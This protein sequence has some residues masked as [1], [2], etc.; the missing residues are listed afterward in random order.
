[1]PTSEC[2]IKLRAK[3]RKAGLCRCGRER[4]NKK[5]KQCEV[6]RKDNR[7]W[8]AR[9]VKDSC[10]SDRKA[11][12]IPLDS[13]PEG[14]IDK[15]FVIHLRKKVQ[16]KCCYC[17]TVMQTEKMRAV[18]D[19]LTVERIDN[20]LPHLKSNCTLACWKCNHSKVGTLGPTEWRTKSQTEQLR[21]NLQ[22]YLRCLKCRLENQN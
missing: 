4:D 16:S 22:A 21:L 11:G 2:L 18:D 15:E 13:V 7:H 8:A 17:F 19:G 5:L 1:M 9:K 12:R 3:R 14:F 10:H 20:D 6:C